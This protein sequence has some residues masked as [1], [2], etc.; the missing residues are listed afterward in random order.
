MVISVDATIG[1]DNSMVSRLDRA[2]HD[3]DNWRAITRT[4][5]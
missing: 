1:A 2:F 5:H 4:P 3:A